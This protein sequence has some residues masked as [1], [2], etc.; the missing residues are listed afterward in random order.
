MFGAFGL[1]ALVLAAVGLYGVVSYG[2]E[3]R[4][5]ELGVRLAL[6]AQPG[7]VRRL[8]VWQGMTLT[9]TGLAIG[10]AGA[11]ALSR[12]VTHLL[13]GVTPTDP[14][15][16]AGVCAMFAAV[17]ALASLIPAGRAARVDPIVALRT[18]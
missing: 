16:F 3:E 6:G 9:L 13:Y 12:L 5:H 1:L 8:V 10:T 4:R 7:Q 14:I 18:E 17:A 11:L 2:V 15:T